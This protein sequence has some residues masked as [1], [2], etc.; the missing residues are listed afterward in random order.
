MPDFGGFS[1]KTTTFLRNLSKNN[2]KAWFDQH[3][4]EYENFWLE[5]AKAFVAAAGTALQGLAPVEYEAKINGS[6]LR[7]NR[8]I[9]FSKDKRPYKD[10]LDFWFWEGARKSAVSGFYLRVGTSMTSI[11]V[12][13]RGFDKEQLQR[14]RTAVSDPAVASTLATAVHS[15]EEAGYAVRGEKFKTI[16][17]AYQVDG[18]L[19]ERMIGH[20]ALWTERG[21]RHPAELRSPDLVDWAMAHWR[22]SAPIHRWLVDTIG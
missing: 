18:P 7:I 2:S 14:Y 22:R 11:R 10:Y 4:A 20:N 8:D 3:Q 15:V 9:R 12:G 19:A 17:R 1:T 13:S 16:A 5:P 6:I 21:Q